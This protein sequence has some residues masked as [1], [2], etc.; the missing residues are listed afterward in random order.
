MLHPISQNFWLAA[1]RSG[2]MALPQCTSIRLC[3]RTAFC[4]KN[5]AFAQKFGEPDLEI[6]VDSDYVAD[7]LVRH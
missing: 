6:Q 4:P 5:P 1:W 2:P 3:L 7:V